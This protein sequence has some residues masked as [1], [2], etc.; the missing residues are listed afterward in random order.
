MYFVGVS[1][2]YLA[3]ISIHAKLFIS[4]LCMFKDRVWYIVKGVGMELFLEGR[5][6]K[7]RGRGRSKPILGRKRQREGEETD[8]SNYFGEVLGGGKAGRRRG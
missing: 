8:F 2:T 6:K 4:S 3:A 7:R 5:Q 1:H